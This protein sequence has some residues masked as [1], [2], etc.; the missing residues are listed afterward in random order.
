MIELGSHKNDSGIYKQTQ[1][2]KIKKKYRLKRRY[3]NIS[4]KIYMS[5]P[6]MYIATFLCISLQTVV[7]MKKLMA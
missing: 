2:F 7:K 5:V 4:R 1:I 3:I 6:Q